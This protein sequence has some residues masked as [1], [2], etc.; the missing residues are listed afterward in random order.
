MVADE[1]VL[2]HLKKRWPAHRR[3]GQWYSGIGQGATRVSWRTPALPQPRVSP[4][5]P[6]RELQIQQ[7]T[8]EA[9][10]GGIVRIDEDLAIL[11]VGLNAAADVGDGEV[12]AGIV[13]EIVPTSFRPRVEERSSDSG[14]AR[15]GL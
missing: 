1:S 12:G 6:S 7:R 11:D 14:P 5:R 8:R 9:I 15:E 10:A 4:V 3:Q 13:R 2:D